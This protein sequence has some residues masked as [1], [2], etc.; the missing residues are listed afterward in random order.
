MSNVS[1]GTFDFERIYGA[2]PRTPFGGRGHVAFP[3]KSEPARILEKTRPPPW[4]T[5]GH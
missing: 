3:E 1:A 5:V 4:K 2:I